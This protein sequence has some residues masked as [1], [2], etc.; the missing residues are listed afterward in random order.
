MEHSEAYADLLWFN[1]HGEGYSKEAQAQRLGLSLYLYSRL[2]KYSPKEPHWYPNLRKECLC[3]LC[4][5]DT[6]PPLDDDLRE[7]AQRYYNNQKTL[8]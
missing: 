7:L 6:N 8:K 2:E 1:R 3:K 4:K 5:G